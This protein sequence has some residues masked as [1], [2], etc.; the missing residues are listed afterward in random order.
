MVPLEANRTLRALFRAA[1]WR[2]FRARHRSGR[3]ADVL[4]LDAR[5]DQMI[6]WWDGT[7]TEIK[8]DPD[9]P[10]WILVAIYHS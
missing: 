7:E 9:D 2:R 3:L 6:G 8:F 1:S 4:G 10:A 5:G